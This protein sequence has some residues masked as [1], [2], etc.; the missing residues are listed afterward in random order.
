[1]RN[2]V[3]DEYRFLNKSKRIDIRVNEPEYRIIT[4]LAKRNNMSVSKLLISLSKEEFLHPR[5]S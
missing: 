3:P 5:L 1:M 4:E 2:K